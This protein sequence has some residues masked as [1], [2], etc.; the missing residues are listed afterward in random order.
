MIIEGGVKCHVY[1][2]KKRPGNYT[3]Y[4]KRGVRRK[5]TF[6]RWSNGGIQNYTMPKAVVSKMAQPAAAAETGWVEKRSLFFYH[7]PSL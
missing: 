2:E 3:T 5:M 6:H 7:P 1:E 4:K